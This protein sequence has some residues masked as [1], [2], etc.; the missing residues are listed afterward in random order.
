MHSP[1]GSPQGGGSSA[2]LVLGGQAFQ[3]DRDLNAQNLLVRFVDM[4]RRPNRPLALVASRVLYNISSDLHFRPLI[5]RSLYPDLS[6]L[7]TLIL[8]CPSKLVE[9]ELMA[10]AVNV[11]L[12][13]EMVEAFCSPE[14]F[15]MLVKRVHQTFDP[16]LV[17][18]LRNVSQQPAQIPLFAKFLHELVGMTLKAPT[19]DFLVES[20]AV[21]A[22]VTLPEVMYSELMAQHGLLDFLLAHM[23]P[24]FADDD[25]LLECVQLLGTLAIDPRA[26]PMLASSALVRMLTQ[27]LTDKIEDLD[28][29]VQ[30]LFCVFKFLLHRETRAA[31]LL[32]EHLTDC[33]LDLVVDPSAE[34]RHL[35]NMCLD[36]IMEHDDGWRDRIRTRRFEAFNREWLQLFANAAPQHAHLQHQQQQ[37]MLGYGDSMGSLG[38]GSMDDL[39]GSG[40]GVGGMGGGLGG[41]PRPGAYDYPGVSSSHLDGM[42]G[43][44]PMG[45]L[46]DSGADLGHYQHHDEHSRNGHGG[47]DDS[48]LDDSEDL[49]HHR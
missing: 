7:A 5:E 40:M 48:H 31:V 2:P 14:V 29:V 8:R 42:D 10:L 9:R 24:G 27:L 32:S 36:I 4:L 17:K 33:L 38:E 46:G 15:H 41:P 45:E 44:D 18:L 21:L 34:V 23:Q 3:Y 37:H 35:A 12:S 28:M 20:L 49:S 13:P 47:G 6:V 25:V 1:P 26:A 43:H 11:T 22:N 30:I 39:S 16:L 19:H